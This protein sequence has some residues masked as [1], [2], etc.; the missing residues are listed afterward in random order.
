MA[1]SMRDLFGRPEDPGIPVSFRRSLEK[2]LA[3]TGLGL[4]DADRTFRQLDEGD[5][6]ANGC[7][8][9]HSIEIGALGHGA[10]VGHLLPS[11][12]LAG[13]PRDHRERARRL[14]GVLRKS[15]TTNTTFPSSPGT[16][17]MTGTSSSRSTPSSD[18]C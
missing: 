2:H 13:D 16:P 17:S 10:N 1:I 18:I 14:E 7:R 9:P 11:W 15:K 5:G 4:R 8:V 12:V 6:R 3:G